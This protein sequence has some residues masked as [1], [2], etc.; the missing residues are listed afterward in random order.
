MKKISLILAALLVLFAAVSLSGCLGGGDDEPTPTPE[1][2]TDVP[3]PTKEAAPTTPAAP[4]GPAAGSIVV[5]DNNVGIDPNS[6]TAYIPITNSRVFTP[7]K[8]DRTV[9]SYL[10]IRNTDT[11][12]RSKLLIHSP[13]GLF[14]DFQLNPNY[15]MYVHFVNPGT[16]T[17]ELYSFDATQENGTLTPFSEPVPVLTVNVS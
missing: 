16:Y 11:K 17:F 13:Q 8:L 12:L 4:S 7:A 15:D 10:R 14:D 1:A 6:D 2:T 9:D 3:E 5:S